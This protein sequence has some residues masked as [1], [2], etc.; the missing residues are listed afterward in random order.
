MKENENKKE[1]NEGEIK[2]VVT[3]P[4]YAPH[5][6]EVL[7]HP[8]VSGIRLN[9]VMPVKESLESLLFRLNRSA[10]KYGKE[11][12][13]DLK[14]RQLRIATFGVPPF[15]E[16]KISHKIDVYT[17]CKIY[18]GDRNE[19]STLLEVDGDRLIMQE[20]PRR[21]VGPGESV[22]IPHPTLKIDG[23]LTD[24]DKRYIEAGKR[25]GNHKYMLSFVESKEDIDTLRKMDDKAEIIAKIESVKGLNYVNTSYKGEAKLMAARGDLYM[26]LHW[27]HKII[28][29]LQD[30]LRNDA[31]A[32]VASRL[33]ESLGRQP[34]PSCE[35]LGDVDNLLR[36]GYRSLM[37]GDE[38]CLKRQTI[39]PALNLLSLMADNYKNPVLGGK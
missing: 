10:E 27:P 8:I 19:P 23:Y 24:L 2:A 16:I 34:E 31:G 1:K 33:F 5:M 35:D 25:V 29:A 38:L 28:N 18:F 13:V 4:P 21:V 7:R 17:P 39:M 22:T 30:I 12:W 3:M 11:L 37:F 36:M 20:G 6:E 15:T 32:Y 26:E 14:G 9:T